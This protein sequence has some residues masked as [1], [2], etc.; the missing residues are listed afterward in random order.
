MCLLVM[1][2]GGGWLVVLLLQPQLQTPG[3]GMSAC[4]G[5][6]VYCNLVM[7]GLVCGVMRPLWSVLPC[8][9]GGPPQCMTCLP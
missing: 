1:H 3:A 2:K 5:G 9:A 7:T 6:R 8:T 4:E